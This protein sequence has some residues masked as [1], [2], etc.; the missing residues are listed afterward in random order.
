MFESSGLSLFDL[1]SYLIALFSQSCKHKNM[2]LKDK[3]VVILAEEMYEDLELWYPLLRM[4]EAGALTIVTSRPEVDSCTS[5][6][7]YPIQLEGGY[8]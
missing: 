4:R 2:E 1:G 5:K 3:K 6:H 7:G 8:S